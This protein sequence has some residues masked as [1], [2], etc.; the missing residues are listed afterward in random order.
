MRLKRN[1]RPCFFLDF[2]ILG[3]WVELRN[4]FFGCW[5]L[6]GC[7]F[8]VGTGVCMVWKEKVAVKGCKWIRLKGASGMLW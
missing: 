4:G 2:G 5:L 3:Y 6:S 8:G 1:K 7:V